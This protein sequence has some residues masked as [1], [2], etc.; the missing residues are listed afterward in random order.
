MKNKEQIA[1]CNWT[2]CTEK[3][4]MAVN[5]SLFVCCKSL[6]VGKF[7]GLLKSISKH[8]RH[9]CCKNY[10]KQ[11]QWDN[12]FDKY[13]MSH[14][15]SSAWSYPCN[16]TISFISICESHLLGS[17]TL[18]WVKCVRVTINFVVP[19]ESV[20]VCLHEMQIFP[21][22]RLIHVWKMSHGISEIACWIIE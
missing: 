2:C 4:R 20:D 12:Y 21:N 11:R 18:H 17:D 13:F 5:K 15:V 8:W 22:Y 16:V 14:R 1:W 7:V 10:S 19:K 9:F 3:I 6:E